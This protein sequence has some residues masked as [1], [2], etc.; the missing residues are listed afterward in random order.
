VQADLGQRNQFQR[1]VRIIAESLRQDISFVD[2]EKA[3]GKS[4]RAV[5]AYGKEAS[6]S[7][8]QQSTQLRDLLIQIAEAVD[9]IAT[10]SDATVKQLGLVALKLKHAVRLEDPRQVRTFMEESLALVLAESKRVQSEARAKTEALDS[11]VAQLKA[12]LQSAKLA[13]SDDPITGLP[14]REMAEQAIEEMI[15]AGREF[16][17]G[18][19]VID[20]LV[21]I[22]GRF[23]RLVG[24]QVL[25]NAAVSLAERLRGA[26]LYRWSGPSFLAVYDPSVSAKVAEENARRAAALRLEKEFQM[27][28]RNALV[29]IT[30]TLHFNHV[31]TQ[32]NADSLIVGL[33]ASLM[34]PQIDHKSKA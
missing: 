23:G 13:A 34:E 12:Q 28:E 4:V 16:A 9:F 26:T 5:E 14:A 31:A 21:S 8:K 1:E 30:S 33:D 22:N 15:S 10:G 20:R 7:F 18:L 2:L 3:I 25:V 29:V 24:D 32:S 11:E 19:F 6:D 27:R 17:I